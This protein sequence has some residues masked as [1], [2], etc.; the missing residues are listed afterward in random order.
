[1]NQASFKNGNINIYSGRKLVTSIAI[2]TTKC[3]LRQFIDLVNDERYAILHVNSII[4]YDSFI[5]YSS[6]QNTF[7]YYKKKKIGGKIG[8]KRLREFCATD[9]SFMKCLHELARDKVHSNVREVRDG[10]NMSFML[11][12]FLFVVVSCLFFLFLFLFVVVSCLFF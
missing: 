8:L 6:D 12:L 9:G 3:D 2:N 10:E 5:A 11:F 7:F 1:M 4:S